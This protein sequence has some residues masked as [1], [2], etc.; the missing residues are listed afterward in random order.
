MAFTV[1]W[2]FMLKYSAEVILDRG[3]TTV[4]MTGA[5][6]VGVTVDV[7][8]QL[9]PMVATNGG[10]ESSARYNA[11]GDRTPGSTESMDRV[12]ITLILRLGVPVNSIAPLR[13]HFTPR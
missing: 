9:G 13:P 3:P 8:D 12:R 2:A 11:T 1:K 10:P 4:C 7:C 6:E 5:G